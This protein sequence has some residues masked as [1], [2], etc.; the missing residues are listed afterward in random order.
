MDGTGKK[1][2]LKRKLERPLRN[3]TTCFAAH[4]ALAFH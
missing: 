2:K 3:Q 1:V 4:M